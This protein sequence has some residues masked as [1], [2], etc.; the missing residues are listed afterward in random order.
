MTNACVDRFFQDYSICPTTKLNKLMSKS[1]LRVIYNLFTI[2]N[3]LYKACLSKYVH[4]K[5]IHDTCTTARVRG[6]PLHVQR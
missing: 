4:Q 2:T 1:P 5:N 6:W 3:K